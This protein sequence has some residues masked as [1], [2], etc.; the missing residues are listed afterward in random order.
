V[1][2]IFS[3]LLHD[4]LGAGIKPKAGA[5]EV[6]EQLS[7]N[8][9]ITIITARSLEPPVTNWLDE[10]MPDTVKKKTRIVAM[11][12]HNDK[13]SYVSG[14]GLTHFV[15]DRGPTCQQLEEAGIRS[16]LFDMPWNRSFNHLPMVKSWEEIHN[17]CFSST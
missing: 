3:E 4:P 13:P 7:G 10:F 12:D 5:T 15:D 16:I 14:E 1:E 6:L 11:G 2:K 17:L 9:S 8:G